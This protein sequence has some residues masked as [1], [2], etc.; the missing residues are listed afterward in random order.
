MRPA[1]GRTEPRRSI[2]IG[3]GIVALY[4]GLAAWSGRL[5]PLARGPLLDGLGPV[6]YRWVSPPPELASTNQ[7]PSS[8]SAELPLGPGGVGT[9]VVFTSD[10]Q[11]TVVVEEGSIGSS[12]GQDAVELRVDPVDPAILR[13]PGDG[14]AVFGNAYRIRATYRPSGEPIRRF[15][16]PID[17]IMVYPATAT[18]HANEHDLLW[19]ADGRSWEPLE[20]N[21]SPGQQQA[22]APVPGRGY[23]LVAGVPAPTTPSPSGTGDEGATPPLA[24]ALLVAAGAALLIGVGLLI[25]T[26]GR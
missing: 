7:E 5:S 21:D 13:A 14:L 18:L 1:R 20:T 8:A 6:N 4:A 15:D 23:V 16:P 22:E 11:V 24:V 2:A 9:Q 17:V 3:L 10:S 26:K 19:S 25:R 12:E